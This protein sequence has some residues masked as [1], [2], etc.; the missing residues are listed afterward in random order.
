MY[1]NYYGFSEKPFQITPNPAFLFRS[2]K[3]DTALTYLEYGLTDNVGFILLTGEVGSGKT[4]LVQYI[5]GRLEA[6]IEAGIIYNTNVSADEMLALV[7]DE[8]GVPRPPGGKADVLVAINRFL[9][10][11]YAQRKRVLLI[12]DEGQNLSDEALEE[13]RLLSNLQSDDQLLLQIMLVGQPELIAKLRQP[14]LRQFAQRIAASYH[15][16]ELDR[17]ETGDYIAHRLRVVG[18]NPDLFTPAAV[19]LIYKLSGGIPRAINLVCQAS[20]VYGFAESA[21]KIGQDTIKLIHQDNLGIGL[22]AAP[23]A[24]P[25]AAS[26]ADGNG[27]EQKLGA[28]EADIKDLKQLMTDRLQELGPESG[29]LVEDQFQQLVA[30]LQQE[31]RQNDDLLRKVERLEFENK[32]LKRVGL[33]MRRKLYATNPPSPRK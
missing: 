1:E 7:L 29:A 27:F 17:Q 2:A 31:R 24:P 8:F 10:D 18:G 16:T 14:S 20:L 6:D 22:A 19:D 5:M 21:Q 12:I 25:P 33:L 23:V 9:I 15:L 3:H 28:L 32:H 26:H 4:T 13:V 11:R 30:L